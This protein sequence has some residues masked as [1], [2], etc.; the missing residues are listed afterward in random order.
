MYFYCFL[1]LLHYV[2]YFIFNVL[3]Q[4]ILEWLFSLCIIDYLQN[5]N[6]VYKQRIK[7]L[8]YLFLINIIFLLCFL[9]T[10]YTI[11]TYAKPSHSVSQLITDTGL[12]LSLLFLI[13]CNH[14]FGEGNGNSLQYSCLGH[15]MDRGAWWTT[16][17]GVTKSWT[18]LR[19]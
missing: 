3:T 13:P 5:F 10:E 12:H 14:H 17:H 19:E 2:L 7:Y 9:T 15:L 4:K 6:S 11:S 16:V 8:V 18:W 1:F